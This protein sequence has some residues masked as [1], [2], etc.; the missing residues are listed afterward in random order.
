MPEPHGFAVRVSADRL[1]A[2][3]Q[4]TG[5][6]DPPCHPLTSPGAVA[7][8]A[9][10]PAFVTTRDP[11]LLSRRDVEGYASDLGQA[12]TEI[13]LQKGLD[14]ILLICPSGKLACPF[15]T[16]SDMGH[17][18][19][20]ERPEM[21]IG[22]NK[23]GARVNRGPVGTCRLQPLLSRL[24]LVEFGKR[25]FKFAIEEPHRIKNFVEGC[26]CSCPV[27]LSKGEDAI[28]SQISHDPRVGNFIVD[29]VA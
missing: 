19:R 7:S 1:R 14:R 23:V 4:L 22:G 15:M 25:S 20:T 13:F 11:P 28:V 2:I 10:R 17:H 18:S 24:D 6:I 5:R 8:T 21:L 12:K 3:R 16:Q 27:S 26:R 9:S 29:Q